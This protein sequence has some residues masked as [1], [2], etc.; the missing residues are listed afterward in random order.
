MLSSSMRLTRVASVKRGGGSV[1]MLGRVDFF[2]GQDLVLAHLGQ[3]AALFIFLVVM[4]F[5]VELQ[6]AIEADDL[7]GRAKVEPARACLRQDFDRRALE[8]GG[9]HWLAMVRFQISS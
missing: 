7:P 8:F 3:T 5:L 2:L 4:A 6:K 9:F 1:K